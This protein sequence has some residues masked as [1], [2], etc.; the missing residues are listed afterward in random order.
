MEALQS[1][2]GCDAQSATMYL[3]MSGG[4][5]DSA[6]ALY[7]SMMGDD[8]SPSSSSTQQVPDWHSLVWPSEGASPAW[9]SQTLGFDAGKGL[10]LSQD[11]NGPCGVLA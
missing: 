8:T 10:A 9:L 6:V 5:V 1:I 11:G 3:E 2:I 4:D 7:F